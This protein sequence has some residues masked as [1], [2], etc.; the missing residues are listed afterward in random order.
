MRHNLQ[1]QHEFN[2][3]WMESFVVLLA[4]E[5]VGRSTSEEICQIFNNH[6]K[7]PFNIYN[8]IFTWLNTIEF[9][10]I[11]LTFHIFLYCYCA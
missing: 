2:K 10:I 5:S 4:C 11:C 3:N 7:I 8:Y 6:T 9:I 1:K